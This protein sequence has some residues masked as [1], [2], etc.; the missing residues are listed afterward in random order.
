GAVALEWPSRWAADLVW[1]SF[2]RSSASRNLRFTSSALLWEPLDS[3]M[4]CSL[5]SGRGRAGERGGARPK[6]VEH[7]DA[8]PPGRSC[9]VDYGLPECAGA[10]VQSSRAWAVVPPR[11]ISG[12]PSLR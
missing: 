11:G 1:C 10:R 5:W 9:Q 12:R 7:L 3:D 8:S 2:L 4:V 6:R